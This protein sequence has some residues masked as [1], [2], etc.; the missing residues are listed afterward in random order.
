ME[1][2]DLPDDLQTVPESANRPTA[3]AGV[4]RGFHRSGFSCRWKRG[5]WRRGIPHFGFRIQEAGPVSCG[6]SAA[7]SLAGLIT[8]AMVKLIEVV[9]TAD[10]AGLPGTHLFVFIRRQHRRFDSLPTR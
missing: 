9:V 1:H 6:W 10:V 3:P 7:T 5:C 2:S 4:H 8:P